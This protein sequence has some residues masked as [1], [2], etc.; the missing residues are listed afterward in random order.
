VRAP[1]QAVF[2]LEINDI[3][4]WPNGAMTLPIAPSSPKR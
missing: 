2:I 4:M 3:E 1:F